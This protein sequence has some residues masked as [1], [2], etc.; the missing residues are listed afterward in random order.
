MMIS[1]SFIYI[2]VALLGLTPQAY[3]ACTFSSLRP[4]KELG[5]SNRDINDAT[6]RGILPV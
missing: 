2:I 6:G 1:D 4:K 5:V 3:K